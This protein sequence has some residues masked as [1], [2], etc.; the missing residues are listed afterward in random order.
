[1]EGGDGT[2]DGGG[3]SR[4]PRPILGI[5]PSSDSPGYWT[6]GVAAGAQL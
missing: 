4:D 2:V 3:G 6:V 1:M 5:Q